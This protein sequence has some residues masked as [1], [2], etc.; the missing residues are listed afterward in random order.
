[1]DVREGRYCII[2]GTS[3]PYED[4]FLGL[5]INSHDNPNEVHQYKKWTKTLSM[6]L[7]S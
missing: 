3:A 1:V 2:N 6:G 4:A 5:D 7:I